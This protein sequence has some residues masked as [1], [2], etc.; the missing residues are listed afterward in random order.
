MSATDG[1]EAYDPSDVFHQAYGDATKRY[2]TDTHQ[3]P[4]GMTYEDLYY[5]VECNWVDGASGYEG[6]TACR[7]HDVFWIFQ[8]I[9]MPIPM[10]FGEYSKSSARMD[11][12]EYWSAIMDFDLVRAIMVASISNAWIFTLIGYFGWYHYKNLMGFE[13]YEYSSKQ[14]NE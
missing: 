12:L 13:G 5:P 7:L 4:N 6:T 11:T 2:A 3:N 9:G 1:S 14:E 10:L 8:R